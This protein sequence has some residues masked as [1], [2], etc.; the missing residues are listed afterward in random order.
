MN[1]KHNAGCMCNPNYIHA[2]QVLLNNNRRHRLPQ[3]IM[4]FSCS[5][6]EFAQ[7]MIAS[8]IDRDG[9]TNYS[10]MARSWG[11]QYMCTSMQGD[12]RHGCATYVRASVILSHVN[13][14]SYTLCSVCMM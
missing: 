3:K 8:I 4:K 11:P 5:Y 14:S 6:F 2:V 13:A 10:E 9:V 7:E 1:Q 12:M